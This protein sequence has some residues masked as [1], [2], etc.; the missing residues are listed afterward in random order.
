MGRTADTECLFAERIDEPFNGSSILSVLLDDQI[1][2]FPYL[3]NIPWR[4]TSHS[5]ASQSFRL[6]WECI[7]ENHLLF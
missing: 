5:A 6:M 3:S 2:L 4:Y 7:L 1:Y